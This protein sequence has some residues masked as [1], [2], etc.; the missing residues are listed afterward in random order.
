[1]VN[2]RE[3]KETVVLCFS[4]NNKEKEC[5]GGKKSECQGTYFMYTL[6]QKV[7]LEWKVLNTKICAG[8]KTEAGKARPRSIEFLS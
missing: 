6:I 4:L 2:E 7:L 5:V 8:N 1:M 3:N